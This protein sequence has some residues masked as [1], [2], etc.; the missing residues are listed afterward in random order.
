MSN[1]YEIMTDRIVA[2]LGAGVVPWRQPWGAIGFRAPM[3]VRGNHYRGLNVFLLACQGYASRCWLTFN[4][5]KELGGHVRAGE[6]ST[7]VVFWKWIETEK[8]NP[9]TGEVS[10]ASVPLLRYYNV[11]NVEQV[12]KLPERFYRT[13]AD[14]IR[15]F[16]AIESCERI[17]AGYPAAPK[18]Q[19]GGP[20][21]YYAPSID[22]V[23]LPLPTAFLAS[24]AYY[25][26]L[27]HELG[28][29]TGH[30]SRL[31][32]AGI[33]DPILL[34]SH[35]YSREELVAEMTAAFLC[36]SAGIDSEPLIENSAAYIASWIRA[37]KG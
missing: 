6:R 25:S 11:F 30:P 3:N 22:T 12:E 36:G 37:M 20:R 14:L 33:T 28:H 34:G 15:E 16:S 24:E 9:E 27:F 10:K 2:K 18:I 35:K 4:Q 26:T 1:V 29:S 19:H 7:P 13:D 21:A 8:Q 17:V 31:A 5:A 23:T 32:R